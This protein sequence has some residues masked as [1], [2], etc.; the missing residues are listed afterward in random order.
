MVGHR[1]NRNV[2]LFLEVLKYVDQ[3]EEERTVTE[4]LW[5]HIW[6]DKGEKTEGAV[7]SE[8]YVRSLLGKTVQGVAYVPVF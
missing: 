3:Y 1:D 5:D 2:Q 4:L 7:F 6:Q 8:E